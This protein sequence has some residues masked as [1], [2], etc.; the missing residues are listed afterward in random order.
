MS[1][2]ELQRRDWLDS[3]VNPLPKSPKFG[4]FTQELRD[5]ATST[6]EVV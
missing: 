2:M 4:G 1:Y 5:S 3:K 6:L